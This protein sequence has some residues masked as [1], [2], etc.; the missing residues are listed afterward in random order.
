MTRVRRIHAKSTTFAEVDL[1]LI[2][3]SHVEAWVKTMTVPTAKRARPLALATIKTRFVSVR[4]VFEAGVRDAMIAV[5]PTTQ[6]RLPRLRRREAAMEIPT[7]E[8]VRSIL[9]AADSRFRA[10]SGFAR[11]PASGPGKPRHRGT[12]TAPG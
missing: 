9:E 7:P 6:V 1:R 12:S 5:D 11:S 8:D 2:R 4:T 3:P 10:W